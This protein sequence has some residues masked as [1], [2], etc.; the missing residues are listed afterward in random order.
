[1][2]GNFHSIDPHFWHFTIPLGPFL[3]PTWSYWPPLSA[4]KISLFLSHFVPE[5]IWPKVGLF[6]HK[7]LLFDTFE[8]ICNTFLLDFRSCWPPFSL[9]LDIFDS[10]FLQS[11][12]S[13]WVHF[14]NWGLGSPPP[15]LKI[16]WSINLYVGGMETCGKIHNNISIVLVGQ[17]SLSFI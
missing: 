7:N 12:R 15:Q 8:A 17:T 3:C 10:S 5:I 11:L 13:H 1:M 4:K 6:F 9:L 14:F 2:V 16:W